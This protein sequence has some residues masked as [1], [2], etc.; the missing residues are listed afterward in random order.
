IRCF[1]I[2]SKYAQMSISRTLSS[3]SC[4]SGETAEWD[5]LLMGLHVLKEGDSAGDLEA[6]DGLGGFP[7]V[8]VGNTKVRTAGLSGLLRVEGGS[9]VSDLK[10]RNLRSARISPKLVPLPPQKVRNFGQQYS[11]ITIVV[12]I[13]QFAQF[14]P[15]HPTNR[16]TPSKFDSKTYHL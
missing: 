11:S 3:S 6:L 13:S 15:K 10:S 12:S 1:S 14:P 16:I 5:A 8:L 9:G 4:R 7:G 2:S